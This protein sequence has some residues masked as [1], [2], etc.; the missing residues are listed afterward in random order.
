MF[1]VC[2]ASYCFIKGIQALC[3]SSM[4]RYLSGTFFVFMQ[5]NS[6]RRFTLIHLSLSSELSNARSVAAYFGLLKV[7][8]IQTRSRVLE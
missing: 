4:L 8:F 5:S 7:T 1:H 2:C 3:F 6:L